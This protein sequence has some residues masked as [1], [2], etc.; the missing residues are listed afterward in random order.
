M[1]WGG[2]RRGLKVGGAVRER[3]GRGGG[4]IGSNGHCMGILVVV[5]TLP[6]GI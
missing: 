2:G 3:L 4:G 5:Q 1:R 6:D